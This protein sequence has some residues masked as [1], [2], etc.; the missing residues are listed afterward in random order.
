MSRPATFSELARHIQ[1]VR[2]HQKNNTLL[3]ESEV[4]HAIICP[5]L[6]LSGWQTWIPGQI[7]YEHA[8]SV[9]FA[10]IIGCRQ[11]QI[12]LLVE[13]K[14]PGMRQR[15]SQTVAPFRNYAVMRNRL[16][17]PLRVESC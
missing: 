1:T 8:C 13:V 12:Q 2:E 16:D 15:I 5:L 7:R 10:D 6:D 11:D 9:G 14:I 17:W 3:K 4:E